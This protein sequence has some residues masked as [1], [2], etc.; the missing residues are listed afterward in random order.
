MHSGRNSARHG[1]V[2]HTVYER[3][4]CYVCYGTTQPQ[5]SS[6]YHMMPMWT[7]LCICHWGVHTA[8]RRQTD[9]HDVQVHHVAAQNMTR[10]LVT[11]TLQGEAFS[12]PFHRCI[13]IKPAWCS[14][15]RQI[16]AADSGWP[17]GCCLDSALLWWAQSVSRWYTYQPRLCRLSR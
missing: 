8:T 3:G 6:A 1:N 2:E 4:G 14:S 16:S 9:R 5:Q 12:F 17:A 15:L 13:C 10:L 11:L 7:G